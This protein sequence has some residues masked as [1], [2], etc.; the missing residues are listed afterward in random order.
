[1]SVDFKLYLITDRKQIKMPLP[2]AV[3]H[4]LS[5]GVKAIQVRE[6][7]LPVRELLSLSQEL[8]VL[9][10]EFGAKLFIND[11]VD[12]AVAVEAD[13]VHLGHQSMPSP[14]VRKIVGN[15]ML[16]G[17]STHN[18]DE[19]RAADSEGA[20]FITFGPIFE[21]PSKSK[22]GNPLGLEA[23]KDVKRA[24][25]IPIF[26]LGGIH[27][28]NIGHVLWSGAYGVAMI[29]AIFG[30]EDIKKKAK[31][32]TEM[33]QIVDRSICVQCGRK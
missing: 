2:V 13:G 16:I 9:T 12:I 31:N 7:D 18:I 10:K 33:I 32:I 11:Q 30:A 4:A 5:G 19:A 22:M 1:M 25:N 20:D 28:R 17:V 8:R 21:T 24:V 29:S 27:G 23:L 6:K 3:R 15:K 14:A 26:A